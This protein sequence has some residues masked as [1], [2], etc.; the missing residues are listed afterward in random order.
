MRKIFLIGLLLLFSSQA[1]AGAPSRPHNYIDD[2]KILPNENNANENA[3][4]NY[5]AAGVDTYEAGSVNAAAI[6]ADAVGNSE[7]DNGASFTFSGITNVTGTLQI[8]GTTVTS[9]ATELNLLDGETDLIT[10]GEAAG[11]DLT[12]TYPNP[13]INDDK[14][15]YAA[16]LTSIPKN[17]QAFTTSGTW[18]QPA[19][20]TTVYVKVWGAGGAGGA[21][22]SNPSSG[23][24]GGGGGYTEG[25]VAVTTDVTVTVGTGGAGG[26]G[27]GATGGTS[28]FAGTTTPQATGGAGGVANDGAGGA[29]GVGSTG[30]INL[31]GQKGSYGSIAGTG[32]DGAGGGGGGRIIVGSIGQAGNIPGGGGGGGDNTGSLRN[33]AAGA[34]GL[35]I[36]YY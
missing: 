26:G 25:L 22:T 13:T 2:E 24:G 20:V 15:T 28:S 3:I 7:L 8:D 23:G 6:G 33:G 35:V 17:I 18:T 11:G 27:T 34:D 16:Q 5:L 19:G 21:A 31:T 1:M 14:V 9:S 32:G 10:S 30:T 12:G 4:Y 29:G 36:V